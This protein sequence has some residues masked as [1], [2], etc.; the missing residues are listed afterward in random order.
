MN[1]SRRDEALAHRGVDERRG[2]RPVE[3]FGLNLPIE[4]SGRAHNHECALSRPDVEH[5][6]AGATR[7][8]AALGVVLMVVM[9]VVVIV[10]SFVRTVLVVVVVAVAV[11]DQDGGVEN[12][13]CGTPRYGNAFR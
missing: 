12:P 4:Q 13:L 1:G 2:S 9:I 10:T 11:Q 3:W 6:G 5:H 8:P 7:L